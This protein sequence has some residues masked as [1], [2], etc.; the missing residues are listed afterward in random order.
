MPDRSITTAR[1]SIV[2][3]SDQNGRLVVLLDHPDAPAEMRPTEAGRVVDGGFQ[4]HMFA[5][6]A[7]T[8][9]GLR[10]IADLIEEHSDGE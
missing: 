1:G 8:P 3:L 10:A 7:L 4:P 2:T 6:W 9:E 5:D